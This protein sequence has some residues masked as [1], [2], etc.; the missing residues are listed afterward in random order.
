MR[1]VRLAPV[2]LVRMPWS[3]ADVVGSSSVSMVR[4]SS[5]AGDLR[6]LRAHVEL[7]LDPVG[8]H[9]LMRAL[10]RRS[11]ARQPGAIL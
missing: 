7:L 1:A 11:I 2:L 6:A 8:N 5:R 10:G 9:Q 3:G 4:Q